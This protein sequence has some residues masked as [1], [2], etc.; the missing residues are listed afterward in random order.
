M[1]HKVHL[2]P[3]HFSHALGPFT[4]PINFSTHLTKRI[5][6]VIEYM[7]N[8]VKTIPNSPILRNNQELWSI[9]VNKGR[10]HGELRY[11]QGVFQIL[12]NSDDELG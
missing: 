1:N 2:R 7:Q 11:F 3:T 10:I 12:I 8:R 4:G 5:R 6:A 9:L